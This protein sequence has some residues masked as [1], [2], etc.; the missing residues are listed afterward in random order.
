MKIVEVPDRAA[1]RA[2]VRE[3]TRQLFIEKNGDDIL[4]KIEAIAK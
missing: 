3:P 2:I 4:K 1:I